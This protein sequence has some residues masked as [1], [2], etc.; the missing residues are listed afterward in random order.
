MRLFTDLWQKSCAKVQ[1]IDWVLK[2]QIKKD[3]ILC[4]NLERD[5][6]YPKMRKNRI[7]LDLSAFTAYTR[8]IFSLFLNYEC[9]QPYYRAFLCDY[10]FTPL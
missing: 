4:V 6:A 7:A 2:W 9:L 3:Y 8:I 10:F 5:R 1:L